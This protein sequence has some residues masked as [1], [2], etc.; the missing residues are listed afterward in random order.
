MA[1]GAQDLGTLSIPIVADS[2]P[3]EDA[4][5][6]DLKARAE[7]AGDEIGR[8]LSQGVGRMLKDSER[9]TLDEAQHIGKLFGARF[10]AALEAVPTGAIQAVDQLS[11]QLAAAGEKGGAEL[12]AALRAK[13]DELFAGGVISAAQQ[14]TL[15]RALGDAGQQAATAFGQRVSAQLPASLQ[16][17]VDAAR[18]KFAEAEQAANLALDARAINVS[19]WKRR[20]EEAGQQLSAGLDAALKRASLQGVL[21]PADLTQVEQFRASGFESGTSWIAGL[22]QA[23]DQKIAQ[24]RVELAD[25][26]IDPGAF[27]RQAGEAFQAFHDQLRA[28]LKDEKLPP[29]VLQNLAAEMEK[30]GGEAGRRFTRAA[31]QQTRGMEAVASKIKAIFSRLAVSIAA[32]FTA[33]ALFRFLDDSATLAIDNQRAWQLLGVAV[34]QAGGDMGSVTPIV[35]ELGTQ[36][37]ALGISSTELPGALQQSIRTT[38]NLQQSLSLVALAAKVATSTGQDFRATLENIS[39]AAAGQPRLLRQYGVVARSSAKGIEELNKRFGEFTLSGWPKIVAEGSVQWTKLKQSIGDALTESTG[40]ESAGQQ[41]VAMLK[42]LVGW[43]QTNADLINALATAALNGVGAIGKLAAK[44]ADLLDK[45]G[46]EARPGIEGIHGLADRFGAAAIPALQKVRERLRAEIA[47]TQ[48]EL[49]KVEGEKPLLGADALRRD[50][51]IQ[52]LQNHIEAL[53]RQAKVATEELDKLESPGGAKPSSPVIP[54][55]FGVDVGGAEEEQAA[56]KRL[57]IEQDLAD[58]IF[59]INHSMTE[60]AQRELDKQVAAYRAAGGKITGDVARQFHQ[61]RE[62]L[63]LGGV[64]GDFEN[65]FAQLS[66]QKI[67]PEVLKSL[68]GLATAIRAQRDALDPT[69]KAWA[70]FNALLD[71]VDESATKLTVEA[72]TADIQ[73]AFEHRMGDLREA[74]ARGLIDEKAF[75]SE[76]E[77]AGEAF[78]TGIL[79]VIDTLRRAGTLTVALQTTLLGTIPDA[80]GGQEVGARRN[81]EL[82]DQALNLEENA[83]AAVQLA[84]AFGAVDSSAAQALE[85]VAQ[86]AGAIARIAGGD[87]TAIPSALGAVASLF[88]SILGSGGPDATQRAEAL[89]HSIDDL[90][91]AVEQNTA[92]L[93]GGKTTTDVSSGQAAIQ[94][95]KGIEHGILTDIH[96][97]EDFAR[98]APGKLKDIASAPDTQAAFAE[99]LRDTGIDLAKLFDDAIKSHDF[100]AFEAAFQA[101]SD[102]L[103]KAAGSFGKIADSNVAG[104]MSRFRQEIDLLD[105]D[106]P[107]QQLRAFIDVLRRIGAGDFASRL[108]AFLEKGDIAGARAFVQQIFEQINAGI[109]SS[110]QAATLFGPDVTPEDVTQ[111]L[112]DTNKFLEDIANAGGSAGATTAFQVQRQI[113]EVTANVLVGYLATI[114]YWSEK[115]ARVN[116]ALYE[117][118]A[119]KSFPIA[120]APTPGIGEPGQTTTG[121][122]AASGADWVQRGALATEAIHALL[123]DRLPTASPIRPVLPPVAPYRGD[124]YIHVDATLTVGTVSVPSTDSVTARRVGSEVG[125]AMGAAFNTRVDEGMGR[126][127]IDRQTTTGRKARTM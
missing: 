48:A 15:E 96:A 46:K 41:L 127:M 61:L 122:T 53:T 120:A 93:G 87:L 109:L 10:A 1:E 123:L 12:D 83:R 106:T 45:P 111:I 66:R 29:E 112:L 6:G 82:K 19:E 116:A 14:S 55:A 84:E 80:G 4:V 50:R 105:L 40:M 7:R 59:E 5:R 75:K 22:R 11:Q 39:K 86:L 88:H 60:I 47:K 95:L 100:R 38:G 92:V 26:L 104:Q 27:Q 107:T 21:D 42:G 35:R 57:Q 52:G 101:A 72:L 97:L 115:D 81:R 9:L 90:R 68:E 17:G 103:D 49:A 33:R 13:L 69:T 125:D 70:D 24:L 118:I 20:G 98:F 102:V 8:S 79:G 76:G 51:R 71:Q 64:M 91:R 113:T 62:Q 78:R 32:F 121:A 2:K 124:T 54:G 31:E 114:A 58:K 63:R 126:R 99:V 3:F 28:R 34:Q 16:A 73:Q 85:S 37:E 43:V 25:G 65:T 110:Q 67:S 74:L 44:I 94:G 89:Q 77:K 56:K 23:R 30:A 108:Q 117:E 119:G 36:I 18:A